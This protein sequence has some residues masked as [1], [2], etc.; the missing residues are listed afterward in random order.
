MLQSGTWVYYKASIGDYAQA[1]TTTTDFVFSLSGLTPS[2]NLPN[3][4]T[5]SGQIVV[6]VGSAPTITYSAQGVSTPTSST[7]PTNYFGLFEYTLDGGGLDIDMSEIDQIGVPFTVTTSPAGPTPANNGVGIQQPFNSLPTLYSSYIAS[8]GSTAA[9]FTQSATA[10]QPYRILAPQNVL[11]SSDAP[12]MNGV[13]TSSFSQG[14]SLTLGQTYYYWVTATDASG[15]SAPSNMVS[16]TPYVASI[17]S[18]GYDMQTV[19]LT[20]NA[21]TGPSGYAPSGYNVYRNRVND[22]T[23]AGLIGSTSA[24]KMTYTDSG[25]G[26]IGGAPPNSSYTY[27]PLNAYFN[28]AIGTFFAQYQTPNSF[29]INV[30]NYTFTGNTNVSYAPG[31]GYTYC[32]LVLTSTSLPGQT[33]VIYQP[34][35]SSNTN[36]AGAPPPPPG[37]T[38]TTQSPAA[39]IMACDGVFN[40]GSGTISDIENRVVSAF[41]RGIA[42]T[43]TIP[44]D[45]WA[46]QPTLNTATPG[47]TSGA[48]LGAGTY[49]YVVTATIGGKESTVS[50][51]RAATVGAGQNSVQLA[52]AANNAPTQYNIYRSTTQGSG[53]QLVG[54]Q[55]NSISSISFGFND[56]NAGPIVTQTPPMYYA[57]GSTSNWYSGFLHTNYTNNNA[58]GVSINGLAYG[59]PYDDDGG[60]STNF[61]ATFTNVYVNLQPWSSTQM[62]SSLATAAALQ[63]TSQPSPNAQLAGSST[64]S[65]QVL[66]AHGAPFKSAVNVAVSLLG[67]ESGSFLVR[68]D[69]NTGI[70]SLT[71][72]NSM[73]GYSKFGLRLDSGYYTESNPFNVTL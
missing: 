71:V 48:N 43:F 29:T 59:F 12:T 24:S 11:E 51:E 69:P 66:D 54:T 23:T 42:T 34:W 40:T 44:P 5:K 35:F 8:Q 3:V 21:F 17:R 58:S 60:D 50:I 10:G 6:G 39:M 4:Y 67:V 56:T 28:S 63:I 27:D 13:T 16:A 25:G 70:G 37:V 49:Y 18:H 30:D 19:T 61:Q 14:G 22:P 68:T 46:A 53:Y 9:L 15:Q 65:F 41:N 1:K 47:T 52:W 36:L 57:P 72:P 2:I 7:N 55:A 64:V 62:S 38:N 32:A 73:L 20:W 45:L 31:N 26:R 33:F